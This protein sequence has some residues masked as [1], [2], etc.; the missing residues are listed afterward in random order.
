MG[1]YFGGLHNATVIKLLNLQSKLV[2]VTG[3]CHGHRSI[4]AAIT[5]RTSERKFG[6]YC[7]FP[8]DVSI[9]KKV[10]L[11]YRRSSTKRSLICHAQGHN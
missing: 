7:G 2:I 5:E 1:E 10:C 4:G 6:T 9:G 3:H 8:R 11:P